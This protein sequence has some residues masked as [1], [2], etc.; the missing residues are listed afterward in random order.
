MVNKRY[1][2]S[3]SA[4][5][6]KLMTFVLYIL[7]CHIVFGSLWIIDLQTEILRNMSFISLIEYSLT[8]FIILLFGTMLLD[9]TEKEIQNKK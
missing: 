5:S 6:I 7:I 9:I 1:K 4:R 8:S 2:F 3:L